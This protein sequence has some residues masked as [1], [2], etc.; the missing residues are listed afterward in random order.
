MEEM[1]K[2]PKGLRMTIKTKVVTV[3]S[4][5]GI[6]TRDF[7]HPPIKLWF[8]NNGTEVHARL[9]FVKSEQLSMLRSVC[10]HIRNIF[11]GVEKKFED[12]MCLK[13]VLTYHEVNG[14]THHEIKVIVM[15]R[16]IKIDGKVRTDMFYPA[17]FQNAM[18][19][20]KTK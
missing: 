17:G 10:N 9:C 12:E 15:H 5:S 11:K 18:E 19:I 6:L 7:E 4:K 20:E 16:L 3:T 1:V 2:V 14:P 8:A 13:Y